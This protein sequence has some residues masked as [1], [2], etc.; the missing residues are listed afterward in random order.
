MVRQE[1]K[2]SWIQ[3]YYYYFQ[4]IYKYYFLEPHSRSR[5]RTVSKDHLN[6]WTY[7]GEKSGG[8]RPG[9]TEPSIIFFYFTILNFIVNPYVY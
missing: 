6:T 8:V 1:R 5:K 9:L 3:N 7:K 2:L 4:F